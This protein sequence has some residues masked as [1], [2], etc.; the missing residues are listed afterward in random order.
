MYV[1]LVNMQKQKQES[2]NPEIAVAGGSPCSPQLFR[3]M[4][5]ILKVKK[6]KVL[7]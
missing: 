4:K 2:I 3:Q 5:D 6:V 7:I 1:D